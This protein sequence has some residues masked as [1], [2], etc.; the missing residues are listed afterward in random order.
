MKTFLEKLD[1]S[2]REINR[3]GETV[4]QKKNSFELLNGA[5]FEKALREFKTKVSLLY[6]VF[7]TLLGVGDESELTPSEKVTM[8]TMYGMIMQS[9]NKQSS[10][11]QRVYTALVI[12]SHAD[13]MVSLGP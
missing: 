6:E 8:A 7:K 3:K 10:T 2:I 12:R 4:L 13:N 11:L 5:V 1:C 9:R